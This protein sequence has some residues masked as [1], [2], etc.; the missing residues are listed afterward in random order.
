VRDDYSEVLDHGFLEFAFVRTEVELMLLQQLQNAAGDLPVLFK[1]LRED[2]DVVQIDHDHAFQDEVLKDGVHHRLR[3]EGG[4]TV[5]EAEEHDK[6]LVQAMVGSEGGLP[7]VSF[8]YPDVVE[9]PSDVQF[10]E[11]LGSTELRNQFRNQQE[12]CR[13]SFVFET[14]YYLGFTGDRL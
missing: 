12:R 7:F 1:G 13:R 14:N 10:C 11:V 8:L 6:G 4:G 5:C 2:E 9:A 3:L